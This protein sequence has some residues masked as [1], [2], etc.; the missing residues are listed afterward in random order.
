MNEWNGVLSVGK[1]LCVYKCTEGFLYS[2]KT[3]KG[4]AFRSTWDIYGVLLGPGVS[5]HFSSHRA[6]GIV[7]TLSQCTA[8]GSV[9]NQEKPV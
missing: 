3:V 7:S 6:E 5:V 1:W 2:I 8:S 9:S 4:F